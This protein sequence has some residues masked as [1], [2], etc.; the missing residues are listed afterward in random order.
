VVVRSGAAVA[1]GEGGGD[2]GIGLAPAVE[3]EHFP[4]AAR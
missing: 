1:S 4:L 3:G 2:L